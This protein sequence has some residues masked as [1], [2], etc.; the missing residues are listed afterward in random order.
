MENDERGCHAAP[1]QLLA[2]TN[3]HG[4]TYLRGT[5]AKRNDRDAVTG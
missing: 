3:A 2:V 4:R 1:L 5:D